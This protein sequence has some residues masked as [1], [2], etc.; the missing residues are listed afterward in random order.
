MKKSLP[1]FGL[2]LILAIVLMGCANKPGIK[3]KTDPND[4]GN[5]AAQGQFNYPENFS[6]ELDFSSI[7]VPERLD[8]SVGIGMHADEAAIQ[9]LLAERYPK[10]DYQISAASGMLLI[11]DNNSETCSRLIDLARLTPG[12]GTVDYIQYGAKNNDD[13]RAWEDIDVL[14][15]LETVL[16]ELAELFESA[17]LT[18]LTAAEAYAIDAEVL[19]AHEVKH[20]ELFDQNLAEGETPYAVRDWGKDDACYLVI[21]TC[22][23][24]G[25]PLYY[26]KNLVLGEGRVPCAFAYAFYGKDGPIRM[27]GCGLYEKGLTKGS[28]APLSVERIMEIFLADMRQLIHVPGTKLN[29]MELCYLALPIGDY[30]DLVPIWAFEVTLQDLNRPIPDPYPRSFVVL[31]DAF[32]GDSC[33]LRYA[34]FVQNTPP[35]A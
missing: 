11:R 9:K 25:V 16:G 24:D 28:A 23:I 8:R 26:R 13:F 20:A 1:V 35:P 17:G 31:Y 32:T 12:V 7:K 33:D 3:G 6:S 27:E 30:T 34:G 10:G 21:Y 5:P 19:Q 15:P 22:D 18:N 29:A 2:I 14:P 4:P